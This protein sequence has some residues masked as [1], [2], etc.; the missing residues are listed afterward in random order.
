MTRIAYQWIQNICSRS[1]RT[2]RYSQLH[3]R[4]ASFIVAQIRAALHL[5]IGL[6][7][8][9]TGFNITRMSEFLQ[10]PCCWTAANASVSSYQ[11]SHGHGLIEGDPVLLRR[12]CFWRRVPSKRRRSKRGQVGLW[13]GC[14]AP[15]HASLRVAVVQY[16]ILGSRLDRDRLGLI[17]SFFRERA[18]EENLK[19]N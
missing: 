11:R 1:L 6:L 17:T 13:T 15:R 12:E 16:S 19:G 8:V 5:D 3:C 14:S 2:F 7:V 4:A 18:R 10:L 9:V